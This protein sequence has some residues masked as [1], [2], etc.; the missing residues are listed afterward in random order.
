MKILKDFQKPEKYLKTFNFSPQFCSKC[1][2]S[3]FCSKC[4][5]LFK[6]LKNDMF[7]GTK[8]FRKTLKKF[9]ENFSEK[10]QFSMT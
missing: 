7:F 4:I 3:Q 2:A 9:F 8:L 10:T 1:I 6:L 5:A